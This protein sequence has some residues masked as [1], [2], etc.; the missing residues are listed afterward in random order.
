MFVY[1]L[2][3]STTSGIELYKGRQQLL[4]NRTVHST[5]RHYNFSLSSYLSDKTEHRDTCF[6]LI[7]FLLM[8]P[9]FLWLIVFKI[10]SAQRKFGPTRH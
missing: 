6:A 9:M 7:N 10:R 1:L 4:F 2:E 5:N 8:I 3:T